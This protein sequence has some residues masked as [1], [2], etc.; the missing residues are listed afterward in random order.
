[1]KCYNCSSIGHIRPNFPPIK[2]SEGS[3]SLNRV[4]SVP[5]NDLMSPYTFIGEVNGFKMPI[6][7]DTGT[8]IDIVPRNRIRP[9]MFTGE[10]I[11]VQQ[12]LVEKH[13]YFPLAE[14]EL[15][16]KFGQ[17]KTKAAVVCSQADKG[18]RLLGN[19]TVTLLEKDR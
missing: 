13:I 6:L 5:D 2:Q 3:A 8:T 12:Q 1:M 9:K 16:G 15:K 11:W 17:L 18:R 10:Q 7:R 4:I 19:R 14:V